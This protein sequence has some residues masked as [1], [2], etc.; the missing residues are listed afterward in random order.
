[1]NEFLNVLEV[2]KLPLDKMDRFIGID[3]DGSIKTASVVVDTELNSESGN[4]I[5]NNVVA[6]SL[7]S[8]KKD[9]DNSIET[10]LND[11]DND[12]A[13]LSNKVERDMNDLSNTVATDLQN[14]VNDLIQANDRL[15]LDV[16]EDLEEMQ[17]SVDSAVD[18]LEETVGNIDAVLLEI[19]G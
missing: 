17:N 7:E 10:L 15:R 1:M 8:Y 4:A 19:L 3:Q 6:E 16:S 13:A 14:T 5:A 12:I 11:V 9:L 2:K 18:Y